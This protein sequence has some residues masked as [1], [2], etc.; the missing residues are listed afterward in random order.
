MLK[1]STVLAQCPSLWDE[2]KCSVVNK[3]VTDL[4]ELPERAVNLQACP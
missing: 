3:L 2:H 1:L 4:D